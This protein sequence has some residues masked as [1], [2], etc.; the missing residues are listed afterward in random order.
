M[1][2]FV[3]WID[4]VLFLWVVASL[5]QSRVAKSVSHYRFL[6]E[7]IVVECLSNHLK[8]KYA[9]RD[10]K[11]GGPPAGKQ[12]DKTVIPACDDPLQARTAE[13]KAETG[14]AGVVGSPS[15]VGLPSTG[16]RR[17]PSD[18]AESESG[19]ASKI[20]RVLDD[21]GHDSDDENDS[22]SMSMDL[23]DAEG[24][25]DSDDD[26]VDV[27]G[28][29]CAA[30]PMFNDYYCEDELSSKY[31]HLLDNGEDD[32]IV[33]FI[34]S[35]P[36]VVGAASE[37]AQCCPV[38]EGHGAGVLGVSLPVDSTMQSDEKKSDDKVKEKFTPGNGDFDPMCDAHW[39]IFV[40]ES[41]HQG[42]DF[43]D[44][45][46]IPVAELRESLPSAH[47]KW[48][49]DRFLSLKQ[50][51]LTGKSDASSGASTVNIF[52]TTNKPIIPPEPDSVSSDDS[53][54]DK[55]HVDQL[56]ALLH[57]EPE[58]ED[59]QLFIKMELPS[60]GPNVFLL[61]PEVY[62]ENPISPEMQ[63]KQEIK[64]E[65]MEHDRPLSDFAPDLPSAASAT[66]LIKRE[67]ELQKEVP[68]DATITKLD[69]CEAIV[70][71]KDM[72]PFFAARLRV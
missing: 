28:L 51:I 53:D 45:R 62:T 49:F 20:P 12:K 29:D 67:R 66:V 68:R 50:R 16:K 63:I 56:T 43:F 46:Q 25:D 6:T 10:E 61:D 55:P 19:H 64:H 41:A 8:K 60:S 13:C 33:D 48:R 23:S 26:G 30:L 47:A 57:E 22:D 72:H 54:E 31:N 14:E 32:E 11:A 38:V 17:R 15:D 7:L 71:M 4:N 9:E 5:Y 44:M 65:I 35:H 3:L 2:R 42:V 34:R 52:K 69:C 58:D 36:H 18:G 70:A 39:D 1:G 24:S 59:D 40:M 37:S 21:E 27:V